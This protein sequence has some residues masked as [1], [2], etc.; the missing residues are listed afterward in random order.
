MPAISRRETRASAEKPWSSTLPSARLPR[1]TNVRGA[2]D[3]PIERDG[4]APR[5]ARRVGAEIEG[6]VDEVALVAA[7]AAKRD[8]RD[9]LSA[10]GHEIRAAP[11]ASGRRMARGGGAQA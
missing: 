2:S 10:D 6:L 1:T 3:T 7:G 5:L 11:A 4:A 9:Q 8:H